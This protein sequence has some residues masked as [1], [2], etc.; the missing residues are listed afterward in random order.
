MKRILMVIF[1]MALTTGLGLQPALAEKH[2]NMKSPSFGGLL[3]GYE[4][5]YFTLR[6][7]LIS[8][9]RNNRVRNHVS[10]MV[11]LETT[12][13]DNKMKII[14]A[15]H[16]LHSAFRRDLSAVLAYRRR[17]GRTFDYRV[18][19]VRLMRVAKRVLNSDIVRNV[20]IKY[21]NDRQFN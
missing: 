8:V 16:Y 3:V 1:L 21:A 6:P 14:K 20:L 12:S 17:D 11:T 15:R 4:P 2:G 18:L 19:K 10:L 9:I 7:F 13:E 5:A